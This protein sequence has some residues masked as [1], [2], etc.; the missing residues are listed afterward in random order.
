M[1][2]KQKYPKTLAEAVD[3]SGKPLP[4]WVAAP[5][6][7]A[8]LGSDGKLEDSQ[9]P[10]IDNLTLIELNEGADINNLPYTGRRLISYILSNTTYKGTY[11][12]GVTGTQLN[13]S[14]LSQYSWGPDALYQELFLY[15]GFGNIKYYRQKYTG[16]W[17]G[18]AKVMNTSQAN[19]PLGF[20][21]LDSNK[22]MGLSFVPSQ[23]Y[24]DGLVHLGDLGGVPTLYNGLVNKI[25]NVAEQSVNVNNIVLESSTD[26]TTWTTKTPARAF[27]YLIKGTENFG[28]VF[29]AGESCRITI[30]NVSHCNFRAVE[31]SIANSGLA[32]K[33][34]LEGLYGSTATYITIYE[35][36]NEIAT[37][38]GNIFFTTPSVVLCNPTQYTTLRFTLI[39][40]DTGTTQ[41]WTLNKLRFFGGYPMVNTPIS[42]LES[43]L[44]EDKDGHISFPAG[45]RAQF[46]DGRATGLGKD[47][48]SSTN[49]R[50]VYNAAAVSQLTNYKLNALI[51]AENLP[52]TFT[53]GNGA[54]LL[55]NRYDVSSGYMI[56]CNH[57]KEDGI[58]ICWKKHGDD[59]FSDW[60]RLDN[61]IM[62][63][64]CSGANNADLHDAYEGCPTGL[65]FV[66]CGPSMVTNIP[67]NLITAANC[68]LIA[69]VTSSVNGSMI[70]I[71]NVNSKLWV[72]YHRNSIY[73]EWNEIGGNSSSSSK[74]TKSIVGVVTEAFNG[75]SE[76]DLNQ[77]KD[78]RSPNIE[79]TD[80]GDLVLTTWDSTNGSDSNCALFMRYADGKFYRVLDSK[81]L[82][83]VWLFDRSGG[84]WW[85]DPG[86][87]VNYKSI[88][89][90]EN[91]IVD[92]NRLMSDAQYGIEMDQLLYNNSNS[93]T[94]PVYM[95]IASGTELPSTPRFYIDFNNIQPA[96][97]I[98]GMLIAPTI[99]Y[100]SG[101]P[102]YRCEVEVY[103]FGTGNLSDISV[104]VHDRGQG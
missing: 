99:Y 82:K 27:L 65:T 30:S 29:S 45:V 1:T 56:I 16:V 8:T 80:E 67:P 51:G 52:P 7:F 70:F 104:N 20:P 44:Q 50:D 64:I 98:G 63:T 62:P 23:V 34:K 61:E 66:N 38:P 42:F 10:G 58:W 4:Q 40:R 21:Q 72:K 49:V 73:K 86:R 17:T 33:V 84:C 101:S 103:N 97:Y 57:I 87:G 6:G 48:V 46:F 37:Y 79:D 35:S 24:P 53:N 85:V 39:C 71:D 18:W 11:P 25:H 55:V 93:N 26:L 96:T 77:I 94:V 102:V 28:Q 83:G 14:I 31:L 68:S 43:K 22:K 15:L 60:F 89:M 12:P 9:L 32:F 36:P 13:G 100:M 81:A 88:L 59:G 75:I 76:Y 2:K 47:V 69:C 74:N 91:I 41:N 5:G 95:K 3:L 90:P 54:F 92:Y 19:I 78:S